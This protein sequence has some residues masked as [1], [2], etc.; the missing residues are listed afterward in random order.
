MT[1]TN[2]AFTLDGESITRDD[3]ME[4]TDDRFDG[5]YDPTLVVFG[6]A[7]AWHYPLTAHETLCGKSIP[8]DFEATRSSN[9]RMCS[10]MACR[11][12]G[13]V[14]GRVGKHELYTLIARAVGFERQGNSPQFSKHELLALLEYVEQHERP[15]RV[16]YYAPEDN[17]AE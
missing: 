13:S 9:R 5:E 11:E 17:D 8:T 16:S 14:L 10:G 15:G 4:R 3:L 6:D 2:G 12:C 1:D 7:E